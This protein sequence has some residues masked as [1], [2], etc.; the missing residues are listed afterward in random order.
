M[1]FTGDFDCAGGVR[2]WCPFKLFCVTQVLSSPSLMN[3]F[4]FGW[5][6]L[7]PFLF[8][9][10][11]CD[12]CVMRGQCGTDPLTQKTIPCIYNGPP[13]PVNSTSLAMLRDVC[14]DL[15][16]AGKNAF[17]CDDTSVAELV[18]N[19]NV[20]GALLKPC[21]SCFLNM[22]R[23]FC[24]MTCSRQQ[25]DFLDVTSNISS[26]SPPVTN[27]TY[28]ITDTYATNSFQSCRDVQLSGVP[29]L[30][31]L[32]GEY[33]D[34]CTPYTLL[35]ALGSHDTIHSPFLIDFFISDASVVRKGHEYIPMNAPYTHCWE[36]AVAGG[37]PCGCSTCHYTC[38]SPKN[39]PLPTAP[40]TLLGIDG[41]YIVM[42][43]TYALFFLIVVIAVLA[44]YLMLRRRKSQQDFDPMLSDDSL[45]DLDDA[46]AKSGQLQRGIILG[47]TWWGRKCARCPYTVLLVSILVVVAL[48]CGL[49]FFTVRTDPVELWSAPGSRA[50]QERDQFNDYFGPFYRVE[51]V[52]ITNTGGEPFNY[53]LKENNE[54]VAFGGVLNRAFLHEVANLQERLL[55]LRA[56]YEG[57]TITLQDICFSP[58]SNGVCMVQSPLNWFLNNASYLD[59]NVSGY[60]YL[61][62]IYYCFHDELSPSD[63]H[64]NKIPCLGSYGG[65]NYPYVALGGFSNDSY[66]D[67][68]A[69]VI[70]ILANNHVDPSLLG[71][72]IAWERKFIDTLKNY[73]HPNVSISFLS[74]NS[75]KDEL[76]R[77]SRSDVYTVLASYMI[78]FLYVSLALGQFHSWKSIF[79]SSR[80]TL[81]LGGVV[82]VLASVVA[83]LGIF[84]YFGSPA[85]L[86]IIEVIPFLVLAVGVDNIFILVQGYQREP[87]TED[88]TIEDR[89]ARVVGKFG[90]SVLLASIS[91]ATCF[92][93][94]GLTTMPAV[95]TFA[96]YAGVALLIDFLLQITC[97]VALLTL[98]AKRQEA[99]RLDVCCWV[100]TKS[101]KLEETSSGLLYSL[102]ENHYAP[103]L[104]KRPVR[105]AVML[106]FVGWLCLSGAVLSKIEVG[107]EQEI[108]MPL[109]SYLQDYFRAEKSLLDVG[110]PLY[111]VVKPGYNYSSYS[112]QNLICGAP[113]S[114]SYSLTAQVEQ[115]VIYE[116]ITTISQPALSWLDDYFT[117]ARTDTCCKMNAT[118]GEF[119]PPSSKGSEHCVACLANETVHNDRP[120]GETFHKFLSNFLA[121]VP[122]AVCPKGGH[123][124]YANAVQLYNNITGTVGATQFMTYH[125]SLKNSQ[126]FTEAL[127]MARFVA[128][129]ITR[130]IRLSFPSSNAT[131]FPYSV[132]HVFY[133]Q[134]LDMVHQ[135]AVH[136]L[137]SVCGVFT[138]T[139]LLLDLNLHAA[140][141]V[142]ATI[143]MILVDLMGIMYFWNISLNAVSLVNLVMATGISVEFCSHVTR[144]YLISAQP[145]KVLRSREALSKM[146][147]SV[148]S[149]ITLTKFGGVVVLAFSKSQLF[150]IFYFRMYL[151]IVLI[152]AAHGLIFLPVLLSYIGPRQART[153]KEDT[154]SSE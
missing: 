34:N 140:F 65:P 87:V 104:M 17:C 73:S 149:G 29:V 153:R 121:D 99:G 23:V 130:T 146:G 137:I 6:L 41:F 84:S 54:T 44:R 37:F 151:S 78:M 148:L 18:T 129:N 26:S 145:T 72:A 94:G 131:V 52:V 106:L 100:K 95:R 61:D 36:P 120:T 81:G 8:V 109:D 25:S 103:A 111:F 154:S 105:L 134:Y 141:V 68:T 9:S 98:D 14:P 27:A 127:R 90:P 15:L 47:F 96:L 144:A 59:L 49:F 89:V 97:F 152:G 80:I 57:R 63:G 147:S 5:V 1:H 24:H 107:L 58:L 66:K 116:Q 136:L 43:A 113:G 60:T 62:H 3:N 86:I 35:K 108:S 125:G 83:S 13:K 22:A 114:N 4:R 85:T 32:C 42:S 12:G 33:A 20:L 7:L 138:I 46:E 119:C 122:S 38:G 30:R 101:G 123:A 10:I 75:I 53:T 82:I 88:E 11:S 135:S 21:P 139:L 76:D 128:D 150:T 74:E 117:W 118:T 91:E 102:F 112:E 64:F 132:F 115:A 45:L 56:D 51:Q 48:S 16:S 124:A 71:P 19:L 79:V 142:C 69:L 92:L 77:E 31:I 93:L 40:W 55:D 50:R 70:T 126:N 133:E 28:Y 110:P 2:L 67:A 143:I 39:Y